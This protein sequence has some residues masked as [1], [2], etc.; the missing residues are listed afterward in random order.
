[1][2]AAVPSLPPLQFALGGPTV[3][4]SGGTVT[5]NWYQSDDWNPFGTGQAGPLGLPWAVWIGGAA[6]AYFLW[7]R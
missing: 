3:A 7:S 2:T 1:M 5:A 4:S 6:L